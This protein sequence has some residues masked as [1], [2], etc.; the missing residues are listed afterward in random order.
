MDL[1]AMALLALQVQ[2]LG[3]LLG[4]HY[5]MARRPALDPSS[6]IKAHADEKI[7]N[8]FRTTAGLY[9]TFS[10]QECR[11]ACRPR[12]RCTPAPCY[13]RLRTIAACLYRVSILAQLS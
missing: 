12:T 2:Y 4:T 11:F 13:S 3:H 8:N 5:T 6:Q 10:I 7:P 1:L 9:N